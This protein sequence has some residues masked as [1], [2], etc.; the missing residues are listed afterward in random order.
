MPSGSFERDAVWCENMSE[1]MKQEWS[2]PVSRER[3]IKSIERYSERRSEKREYGNLSMSCMPLNYGY[4]KSL[5]SAKEWAARYI[6]RHMVDRRGKH[7]SLNDEQTK[8]LGRMFV[9]GTSV[10]EIAEHFS[11]C[12][13]T[14]YATAHQNSFVRLTPLKGARTH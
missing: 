11:I 5:V 8:E 6:D 12:V 7:R 1:I 2:N 3:R 10:Q 4:K 14:V 13:A 9:A